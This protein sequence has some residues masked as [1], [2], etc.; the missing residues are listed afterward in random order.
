M[1]WHLPKCMLFSLE[2]LPVYACTSHVLNFLDSSFVWFHVF[3]FHKQCVPSFYFHLHLLLVRQLN[4][5]Q[6]TNCDLLS[7][8]EMRELHN[9]ILY[10]LLPCV[11]LV[12]AVHMPRLYPRVRQCNELDMLNVMDS[13]NEIKLRA[14]RHHNESRWDACEICWNCQQKDKW[15]SRPALE[16]LPVVCM[17]SHHGSGHWWAFTAGLGT[18][19]QWILW[20]VKFYIEAQRCRH[21]QRQR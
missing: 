15:C 19:G 7:W 2:V 13:E 8:W 18:L 1:K 20:D 4:I 9:L 16:K 17:H 11:C 3:T 21:L 5:A 6:I 10:R 12:M 14:H